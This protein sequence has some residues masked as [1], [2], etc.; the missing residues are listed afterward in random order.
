MP[1]VCV[2]ILR[3]GKLLT[4]FVSPDY[5]QIGLLTLHAWLGRGVVIGR[6]AWQGPRPVHA[7]Y[8]K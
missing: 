2:A 1:A 4:T 6:W 7:I 5:A 8:G 3:V